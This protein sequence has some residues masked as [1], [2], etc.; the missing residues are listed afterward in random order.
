M[1][2]KCMQH[3]CIYWIPSSYGPETPQ[4]VPLDSLGMGAVE[5]G[6]KYAPDH[7]RRRQE[8]PKR[9]LTTPA[10]FL[11]FSTGCLRRGGVG[12]HLY[13]FQPLRCGWGILKDKIHSGGQKPPECFGTCCAP[14]VLK[15][16]RESHWT[17][18]GSAPS[19]SGAYVRP[20]VADIARKRRSA[21]RRRRRRFCVF[22]LVFCDVGGSGVVFVCS[23]H[24]AVA[25]GP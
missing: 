14:S 22:V 15:L 4:G 7:R 10:A 9:I 12:G 16:P 18:W 2:K 20:I 8:A 3:R 25:G 19:K 21:F 23:T 5:I 17:P 6:R 13:S 11:G 1:H 24:L